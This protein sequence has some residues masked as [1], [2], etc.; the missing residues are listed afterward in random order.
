ML[1]KT[2]AA[3][4]Q[5]TLKIEERELDNCHFKHDVAVVK[6]DIMIVRHVPYMALKFIAFVACTAEKIY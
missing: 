1:T 2:L 5:L 6:H 3:R 4:S